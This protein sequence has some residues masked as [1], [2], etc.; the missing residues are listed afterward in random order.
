MSYD[1]CNTV[2]CIQQYVYLYS[3]SAK[4][5]ERVGLFA[6]SWSSFANPPA[7][8]LQTF[9]MSCCRFCTKSAKT[10]ELK[11]ATWRQTYIFSDIFIKQ[12]TQT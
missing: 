8:L 12:R 10:A 11:K 1:V 3:T 5:A 7:W 6:E 4:V 9:S 2:Y